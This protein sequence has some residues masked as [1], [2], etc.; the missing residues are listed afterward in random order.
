MADTGNPPEIEEVTRQSA[1][2]AGVTRMDSEAVGARKL[3]TK[4]DRE[5][6]ESPET[7]AMM[8][9]KMGRIAELQ[10][11]AG[12]VSF[13]WPEEVLDPRASG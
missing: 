10:E 6:S 4:R 11:G 3:R 5:G 9:R 2:D 12:G 13:E 8:T 1:A 7:Q